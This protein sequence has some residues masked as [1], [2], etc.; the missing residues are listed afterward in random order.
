MAIRDAGAVRERI[1]VLALAM[2]AGT[3]S[4]RAQETPRQGEQAQAV[5]RLEGKEVAR[6]RALGVKSVPEQVVLAQLNTRPGKTL[7]A[8]K[9][10]DDLAYLWNGFKLQMRVFVQELPDG[11]VEVYFTTQKEFFRYN[12]TVFRGLDHFSEEQVR[13][14]LG[15]D[16]TERLTQITAGSLAEKLKDRYQLDGY[17]H[18]NVRIVTD[19]KS[20]TVTFLVDEGPR[21]RV[22]SIR[23]RG[24][25]AFPA[26]TFLRLADNLIGSA[27]VKST[28]GLFG[29]APFSR[30]TLA[31]DLDRVR[32]YY[33]GRG[34]KDAIVEL[35]GLDF[36]EDKTGVDIV[37]RVF[38]GSLY[39]VESV[40]VRQKPFPATAE[41]L[42]PKQDLL[43]V[44][45]IKPGDPVTRRAVEADRL[46]LSLFYGRRGFPSSEQHP[47]LDR[48]TSFRVL[49]PVEIVDPDQARVR[50][51][52]V[53]REGKRKRLRHVHIRGNRFTRD[54]V[55]RR[56][57]SVFP[58]EFINMEELARSRERLI[59]K[60]YFGDFELADPGVRMRL[61]PVP[62]D[63]ELV[64]LNVEVREGRTGQILWG[65]GVSSNAGIFG[66]IQY[67]KRNFD[68]QR[69]PSNL[70][71]IDWF[72]E[73]LDNRAF[74]GG[75][76]T[77]NLDIAPGTEVSQASISFFE[78]DVLGSHLN[79]IGLGID[80]FRRLRRFSTYDQDTTGARVRL[81]K[82]LGRDVAIGASFTERSIRISDIAAD[83][84]AIVWDAEGRSGLRTLGA[85]LSVR[86]LDRFIQPTSGY[87]VGVFA[88]LAPEWIGSEAAYW[89]AGLSTTAYLALFR[90]A[91]E[92]AHVVTVRN[93][94]HVGGGLGDDQDLYLTERFFMGGQGTL[95]GFKFRH[96]GPT[97]FG[98][99]TG[100]ETM[101]LGALEYGFPMFSTRLEGGLQDT[102]LIRGVLF[103]DAGMLGRDFEDPFFRQLRLTG[104]VGVRIRVPGL[105][106][107]PIA[108]DFGW[109]I[110]RETTDRL[111]VFSFSF[112]FQ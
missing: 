62:E 79:I 102:E 78:P 3:A 71:P 80:A 88:N 53:I 112:R 99:P 32:A 40:D 73:I 4:V 10:S 35:Y 11:R 104:G 50:L 77:L 107:L 67:N 60:R 36:T 105:G 109:P 17:A 38:E 66:N 18:V 58:G 101:Y 95:R 52:Y 75:G 25:R 48:E 13:N 33:R 84:P 85:D 72:R 82:E 90:D 97:Q 20:S 87:R 21:A 93:S 64:D 98:R 111:E 106:G 43:E 9:V 1:A 110:L 56:E 70:N 31:E 54:Q 76:Q 27:G 30:K 49:D 86:D 47:D 55:I 57:L 63:P 81:R 37:V 22:R 15:I 42:F 65:V 12:R 34:Y 83:A 45:K 16:Q 92:R 39:R 108:F 23:F 51:V 89:T 46:R 68:W 69:P 19:R 28:P 91:K 6:V 14:I 61:V 59:G 5:R 2:L 29:N 100:G 96:A 44:I 103:L 7:S 8:Q 74:H 41:P 94:L 26:S 24:N